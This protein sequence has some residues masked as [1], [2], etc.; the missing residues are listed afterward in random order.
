M[1]KSYHFPHPLRP[2]TDLNTGYD[3][4]MLFCWIF[5]FFIPFPTVV[6]VPFPI[7]SLITIFEALL[8]I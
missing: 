8:F 3:F 5:V 4:L 1:L 7:S 6:F 2:V